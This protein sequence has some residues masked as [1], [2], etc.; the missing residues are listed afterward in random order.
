M[1]GISSSA[2]VVLNAGVPQG[3]IL[4]PILCIMF[5]NGITIEIVSEIVIYAED[6]VHL[7][8]ASKNGPILTLRGVTTYV[9]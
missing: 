9:S 6:I 7:L 5:I 2:A 3:S 1:N 4:G 8:M